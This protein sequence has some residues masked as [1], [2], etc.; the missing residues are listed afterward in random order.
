MGKIY[1]LQYEQVLN[2]SM[3]LAW[4][5]FS[6]ADNLEKITPSYM[7]YVV[8]SP[9]TDKPVYAGQIITYV[10]RPV[11][12]I[13]LR[14]MT[15]ITHVA[16]GRYFVDE[17]RQGPYGFWHHQHHFEEVPE[18][19]RMTD[20]V[21]YAMPFGILGS[22]AHALFVQRQLRDIFAFRKAAIERLFEMN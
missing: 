12:G 2:T 8:T 11:L 5:F 21:H 9:P 13:P 4:T 3:D 14:W 1:R 16:E 17:Q 22:I 18:G 19:V 20:I 6:R 10:I 15:E 7:R